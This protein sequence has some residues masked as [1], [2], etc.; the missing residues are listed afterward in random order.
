M[1]E[2]GELFKSFIPELKYDDKATITTNW[3]QM[4][5]VN[6]PVAI[7]RFVTA[8][9][10]LNF[11]WGPLYHGFNV[12]TVASL[13]YT[14][15]CHHTLAAFGVDEGLALNALSKISLARRVIT[16]LAEVTPLLSWLPKKNYIFLVAIAFYGYAIHM[17]LSR[18]TDDKSIMLYLTLYAI[19]CVFDV[20]FFFSTRPGDILKFLVATVLVPKGEGQCLYLCYFMV[21]CLYFWSG[22]SKLR[23]WFYRFVFQYWFCLMSPSSFHLKSLYLREDGWPRDGAAAFAWF[24]AFQEAAIG[25]CMLLPSCALL[26]FAEQIQY[27]AVCLATLMHGFIFVFGI[28]PYRWNIMQVYLLWATYF[29][30]C[31]RNG[32]GAGV[33]ELFVWQLLK[34]GDET[35]FSAVLL[36]GLLFGIIIPITGLISTKFLGKYLGGYRMANFHFAGNEQATCFLIET[37]NLKE[38]SD[39]G[40][41]TYKFNTMEQYSHFSF[42]ADSMDIRPCIVDYEETHT[43][44]MLRFEMLR[45]T[46][47]NTKFDESLEIITMRYAEMIRQKYTTKGKMLMFVALSVDYFTG[48]KKKFEIWD[49]A[50]GIDH[51]R[52]VRTG[53]VDL[54][55]TR[56]DMLN[57]G[58]QR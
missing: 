47:L 18:S 3:F 33:G 46:M 36:Y 17:V 35:K 27:G 37:S 15:I 13:R 6:R 39:D 45:S 40:K 31:N 29:I 49:L 5:K 41:T 28:G 2:L 58:K 38:K 4:A 26:P 51:R 12:F 50:D 57:G 32:D 11:C 42:G 21:A 25:I 48:M 20:G 43:P 1:A 56:Y 16:P 55:W 30:S 8:I 19:V 22:I 54:P 9:L 44:L 10:W 14:L 7:V 34:G 52:L 23:G 53:H 24:G